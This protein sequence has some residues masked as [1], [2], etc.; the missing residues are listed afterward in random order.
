MLRLR[1]GRPTPTMTTASSDLQIHG[2]CSFAGSGLQGSGMAA[3]KRTL[4][5]GMG[6]RREEQVGVR[7]LAPLICTLG[8]RPEF[9]RN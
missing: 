5:V 6:P 9:P 3:W 7:A 4:R 1:Q 8:H 2:L